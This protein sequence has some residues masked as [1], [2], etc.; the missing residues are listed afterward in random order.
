L[1]TT[2]TNILLIIGGYSKQGVGEQFLESMLASYPKKYIYRVSVTNGTPSLSSDHYGY[3]NTSINVKNSA[4][5]IKAS[6][7][8]RQ[9]KK[10]QLG[11]SCKS[12]ETIIE[13]KNIDLVWVVINNFF[14]LQ[15]ADELTK[16]IK[17]PMI[18]HIWDT[19]EYLIKKSFLDSFS[20]KHILETFDR[21]MA[22]ATRVIS[23]SDSMGDI[24]KNKYSVD[25]TTMVFCPPKEAWQPFQ[26]KRNKDAINIIFAGSL[27][28]YKEWNAFLDAVENNNQKEQ[29]KKINVTCVGNISRWAKKRNWVNYESLKPIAEAAKLVNEADI[30]YL[31]YWMD[32]SK[33]YFVKTAF[34][35][36][37]SF[38]VAAGTPVFFHGPKDST[39][40][41]FL[42]KNH[43]GKSCHSLKKED[44]IS[45][46]NELLDPSFREKYQKVQP[47]VLNKF[48]HP[49]RLVEQFN[50]VIH[51]S[52][53]NH[54]ALNS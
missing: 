3:Q 43:V 23:V 31:P 6:W 44:I 7:Y 33:S 41:N 46:I 28:A 22:K 26:Q 8:Y 11:D 1:K 24:Y 30:A 21:V 32:K 37:M 38:Y 42:N 10:N 51:N 48:F 27:Y 49:N 36:K 18:T 52:L 35:G 45:S 47:E 4:Y 12:V 25:Y 40:T 53:T 19:P 17:Q 20:K 5:P 2:E 15:I 14:V 16:K 54:I 39:P 50:E 29:G 9:F 13:E 34:P